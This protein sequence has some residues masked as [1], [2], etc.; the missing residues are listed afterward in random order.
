MGAE[1]LHNTTTLPL[2]GSG[3]SGIEPVEVQVSTAGTALLVHTGSADATQLDFVRVWANNQH[4]AAIDLTFTLGGDTT[5]D[6]VAGPIS[7]PAGVGLIV[8]LPDVPVGSALNLKAYASVIN[9]VTLH[10][11]VKRVQIA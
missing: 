10:G 4:T 8:V 6:I 11:Y 1:T 2:E 5:S 7:L 3:F 9:K